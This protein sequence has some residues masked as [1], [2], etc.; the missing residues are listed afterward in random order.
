MSAKR[1]ILGLAERRALLGER[2]LHGITSYG[3]SRPI[4]KRNRAFPQGPVK[5]GDK[6][7]IFVMGDIPFARCVKSP[8]RSRAC[9]PFEFPKLGLLGLRQQEFSALPALRFA[10]TGPRRFHKAPPGTSP[11]TRTPDFEA[12]LQAEDKGFNGG[13]ISYNIIRSVEGRLW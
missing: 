2:R 13:R 7:S 4:A 8:A 5:I 6:T 12:A 1:D 9:A 10:E 3:G 11:I